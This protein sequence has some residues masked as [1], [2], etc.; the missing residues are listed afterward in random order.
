M[1]SLVG[2]LLVAGCGQGDDSASAIPSDASTPVDSTA[3]VDGG[4]HPSA[5]TWN[6]DAQASH[7]ALEPCL[8]APEC[9]T[10]G[11]PCGDFPLALPASG[12]ACVPPCFG[13]VVT[14][15]EN[16]LD[17]LFD[18]AEPPSANHLT[19]QLGLEAPAPGDD[20]ATPSCPA[21]AQNVLSTDTDFVGVQTA[22]LLAPPFHGLCFV[23][24]GS[25]VPSWC[26]A[27]RPLGPAVE[28]E[29]GHLI[30]YAS[31]E[32]GAGLAPVDLGPADIALG[33]LVTVRLGAGLGGQPA[34]QF[35]AC[36][37]AAPD[38][39]F[40]LDDAAGC[41]DKGGYC[42]FPAQPLGPL[43]STGVYQF[44]LHSLPDLSSR[45][46]WPMQYSKLPNGY[47][48]VNP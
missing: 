20:A 47:V 18:N 16:D 4:P 25:S 6:Q 39:S 5:T 17:C 36:Y 1:G 40:G 35:T 11:R 10:T 32:G 29:I 19:V 14:C 3:V 13:A 38:G 28:K 44:G 26:E 24:P 48:A 33:P 30:G 8:I 7:V 9:V 23:L 12:G 21:T 46:P 2:L 41:E 15:T 43:L 31:P 37:L 22:T 34:Y 42:C 27:F 45:G